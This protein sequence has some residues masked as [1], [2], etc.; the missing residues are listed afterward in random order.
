MV[1]GRVAGLYGVRGWVK[2]Y[3]H[4]QPMEALL[5]YREC[6]LCLDG[7]WRPR[8]LAEGRR[9]GKGLVARF[10]GIED[11]DEAAALVG[12]DIGVFRESLPPTA[13][14]QYYWADLEGLEVRHTDGRVLGR[15]AYLLETG[16]HDVLAVRSA[17]PG[18]EAGERLIPF[19]PGRYVLNVDLERGVIDVDWEWD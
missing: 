7:D 1:L 12:A 6:L 10:A 11:R 8:K 9:Q 15:V 5:G 14:D 13:E 18:E 2:V 3:S 16:A 4:T 19:V 17:A